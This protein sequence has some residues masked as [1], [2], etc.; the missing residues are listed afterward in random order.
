MQSTFVIIVIACACIV[1]PLWCLRFSSPTIKTRAI[2]TGTTPHASTVAAKIRAFR[3]YDD[4]TNGRTETMK[5]SRMAFNDMFVRP[6]PARVVVAAT[7]RKISPAINDTN[8]TAE[9][10]ISESVL[11][12]RATKD[13][14][15]NANKVRRLFPTKQQQI[16]ESETD[17]SVNSRPFIVRTVPAKDK[18]SLIQQLQTLRK[19]SLKARYDFISSAIVS[20]G[21]QKVWDKVISKGLQANTTEAVDMDLDLTREL[22]LTAALLN[23]RMTVL[24]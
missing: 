5:T 11:G 6:A 19:D 23:V 1:Q 21:V 14:W 2:G 3:L 9:Y 8:A 16:Q 17:A 22:Y 20:N 13:E 12:L 24:C 10:T 15:N 4:S 18:V 7:D